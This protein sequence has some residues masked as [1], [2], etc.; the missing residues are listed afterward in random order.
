MRREERL[1]GPAPK[2]SRMLRK[3]LESDIHNVC[4]RACCTIKMHTSSQKE[5]FPPHSVSAMQLA[6]PQSSAEPP[7][8]Q[9]IVARHSPAHP[10]TKLPKPLYQSL[11]AWEAIPG[12]SGWLLG[13]IK[14]GYTL[15]FRRRPPR[16][17]GVVQSLTLPRNAQVLK[18]E[19]YNLLEKGAIEKVPQS[20]RESRF[21]SRYF[22]VPKRDLRPINRALGKRPFR[23]LKLKQILAQISPG[24]WFAFVDLK[25]TYFHIQIAPH[26]RRFLRFAFK[27]TAYQYSVLPFGLALAPRTFSKCMDAALSP[28]RASGMCILNYL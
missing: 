1:G 3:V 26:H 27:G 18:Q 25:D 23:M 15:Q 14:L 16:F 6:P 13:V 20:E 12:I 28:L 22:V 2:R 10:S 11:K 9:R 5:L 4:V 19:V 24:D 21:Y 8:T 17:N 7:P